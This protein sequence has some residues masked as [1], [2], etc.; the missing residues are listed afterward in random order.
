MRGAKTTPM[1]MN[2]SGQLWLMEYAPRDM[3]DAHSV[4]YMKKLDIDF[5][6]SKL[7]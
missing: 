2:A 5:V 7:D 4:H 1:I 3:R 6:Y